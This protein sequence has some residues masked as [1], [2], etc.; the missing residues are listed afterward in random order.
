MGLADVKAP[1]PTSR[2]A[3]GVVPSGKERVA[4]D[5][6]DVLAREAGEEL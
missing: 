2:R 4:E 5:T 3:S 6:A 1:A